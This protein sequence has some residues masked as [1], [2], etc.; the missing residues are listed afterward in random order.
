MRNAHGL[1]TGEIFHPLEQGVG[2]R[3]LLVVLRVFFLGQRQPHQGRVFRNESGIDV[4]QLHETARKQAGAAEKDERESHFDH[5]Q[6][7]PQPAAR[8]AF[9]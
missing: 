1:H 6:R 9:R 5:Y 2:E 7:A 8:A 3:R 4:G